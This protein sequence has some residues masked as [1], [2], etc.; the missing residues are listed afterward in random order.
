[1]L[2]NCAGSFWGNASYEDPKIAS[3]LLSSTSKE[4]SFDSIINEYLPQAGKLIQQIGQIP[5]VSSPGLCIK[6]LVGSKMR[7]CVEGFL[8]YHVITRQIVKLKEFKLDKVSFAIFT[9]EKL[10]N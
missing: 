10:I 9:C 8:S 2:K 3:W 6:S 4:K 7:A 1:M 5:G